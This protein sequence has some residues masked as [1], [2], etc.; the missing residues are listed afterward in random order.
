MT[1]IYASLDIYMQFFKNLLNLQ[2]YIIINLFILFKDFRVPLAAIQMAQDIFFG[3]S[4]PLPKQT[5][6]E[7]T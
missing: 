1:S 5:T 2:L 4:F 7:H 3:Q 6:F